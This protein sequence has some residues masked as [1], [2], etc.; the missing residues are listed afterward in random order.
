MGK[1][2]GG[3]GLTRGGDKSVGGLLGGLSPPVRA[4]GGG[5]NGLRYG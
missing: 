2:M 5:R 1:A 4:G 3:E